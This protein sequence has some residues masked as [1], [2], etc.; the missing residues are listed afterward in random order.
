[1]IIQHDNRIGDLEQK[2]ATHDE[3]A[4][5]VEKHLEEDEPAE[6]YVDR[7]IAAWVKRGIWVA[8][9]GVIGWFVAKMTGK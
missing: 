2:S 5:R 6:H 7:N 1:M 4:K 3:V 9:T 8:V